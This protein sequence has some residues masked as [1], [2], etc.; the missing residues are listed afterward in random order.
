MAASALMNFGSN[1]SKQ[2]A[3]F[4][5]QQVMKQ[6]PTLIENYEPQIEAVLKN[7]LGKLKTEHPEEAA[8]FRSNWAKLDAVVRSS[9]GGRRGK[10]T[11]RR[12]SRKY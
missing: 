2:Q 3:D 4:A 8:L 5:R 1:F 10:R 12:K 6:I 11:L 9:L 7:S